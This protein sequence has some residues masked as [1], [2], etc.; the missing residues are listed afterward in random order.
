MK[1][2]TLYLLG[3][4]STL[5]AACGWL[6]D[7]PSGRDVDAAV[8]RA[9]DAENHG[10]L[11]TLLGQPLPVSA[12][13]TSVTR[14][15]DCKKTAD[16]TYACTVAIAWHNGR[17]SDG[18]NGGSGNGD[19]TTLHVPLSF[20]Q[21]SDGAWQTSNVDAALMTS[22]AK[23]LIDRVGRALHDGPGSAASAAE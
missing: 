19:T 4:S 22:A 13:V 15:G 9:L 18:D 11:S 20:V 6:H 5:L 3:I 16:R 10:P 8:R 23:S 2:R 17:S 21:D 7:G 14:D 1:L 12:D